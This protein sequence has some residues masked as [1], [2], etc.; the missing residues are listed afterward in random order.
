MIPFTSRK[1]ETEKF[2]IC[3]TNT[4]TPIQVRLNSDKKKVVRSMDV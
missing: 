3:E 2:K 4:K 1:V